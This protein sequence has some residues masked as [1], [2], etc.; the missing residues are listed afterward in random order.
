MTTT[1]VKKWGYLQ[2]LLSIAFAVPIS[3][4]NLATGM[5]Y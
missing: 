3:I 5:V 4:P 1:N 2:D